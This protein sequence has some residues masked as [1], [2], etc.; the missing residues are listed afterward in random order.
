VHV[1]VDSLKFSI[2]DAKHDLLYK[3]LKPIAVPLVKKQ[4]QRTMAEAI[5]T[6]MEYVDGQLVSVRDRMAEAKANE[7]ESRTHVLQDVSLFVFCVFVQVF[8]S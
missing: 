4:I 8:E 3:T 6:G 7:N 2:R 1:K 5:R